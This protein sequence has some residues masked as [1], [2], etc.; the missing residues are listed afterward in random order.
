M[1]WL[2]DVWAALKAGLETYRAR[3]YWRAQGMSLDEG[4]F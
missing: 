3:R 1:T 4:S 2:R